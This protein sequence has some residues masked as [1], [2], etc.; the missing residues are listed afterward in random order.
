M[1]KKPVSLSPSSSK[2]FRPPLET[3]RAQLTNAREQ[4]RQKGYEA[5]L[6]IE[7]LTV[8]EGIDDEA[9]VKQL[10]DLENTR[11]NSYKAARRMDTLLAELPAPKPKT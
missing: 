4:F 2:T 10:T 11:D 9:R 6:N 5:E 1:A 7:A 3:K 8:Q